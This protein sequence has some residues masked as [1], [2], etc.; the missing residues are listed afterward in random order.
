MLFFLTHGLDPTMTAK[1]EISNYPPTHTQSKRSLL[2]SIV[3]IRCFI[4]KK[5]AS[6][7]VSHMAFWGVN[8]AMC[9]RVKYAIKGFIL[10]SLEK[11]TGEYLVSATITVGSFSLAQNASK[12]TC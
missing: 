5:N 6:I 11:Y 1:P 12:E 7:C 4:I 2:I 8:V 10:N 9:C 3:K